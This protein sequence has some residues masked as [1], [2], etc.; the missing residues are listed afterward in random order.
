MMEEAIK[1]TFIRGS[2]TLIQQIFTNC[3]LCAWH[4][5]YAQNMFLMNKRDRAV[6]VLGLDLEGFGRIQ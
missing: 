3:S 1:G 2:C 5:A 6:F 4:Q